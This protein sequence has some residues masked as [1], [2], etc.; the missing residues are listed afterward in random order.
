MPA[1]F[2]PCYTPVNVPGIYRRKIQ[3]V[4]EN[5]DRPLT[6][7]C[8][9]TVCVSHLVKNIDSTLCLVELLSRGELFAICSNVSFTLQCTQKQYFLVDFSLI[10]CQ[11]S[12]VT[13]SQQSGF[14]K[15]ALCIARTAGISLR[16]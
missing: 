3:F 11:G 16:V 6:C 15:G 12:T 10:D 7:C 8:S 5:M 14:M 4:I 2:F 9:C 1:H 13:I